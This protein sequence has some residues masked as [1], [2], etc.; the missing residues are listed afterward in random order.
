MRNIIGTT[1]FLTSYIDSSQAILS[2]TSLLQDGELVTFSEVV[3]M[4]QLNGHAPIRI[5]NCKPHSF[6]LDLDTGV[7]NEYA[8][9]GIVTQ[10]KP[11]KQLK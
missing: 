8:R 11:P 1:I 6:E 7:Y 4:T 2:H 5:K 9:G 3:G 10:F